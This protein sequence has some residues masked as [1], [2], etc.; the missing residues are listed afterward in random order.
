M[1]WGFLWLTFRLIMKQR[2]RTITLFC[3]IFFSSFLLNAFGSLGYYF[4]TQ[5]HE[6]NSDTSTF[7][8]TELALTAL[9]VILLTIVLVC[10]AVLLQNLFALTFF[11]KWHSLGRLITLGA[12]WQQL[13]LMVV[14]EVSIIYCIA[15]PLGLI[16]TIALERS[17]SIPVEI[18]GWMIYSIFSW[19][20]IASYICGL[21]P[22]HK[23]MQT[24]IALSRISKPVTIRFRQI[25]YGQHYN[26]FAVFMARKYRSANRGH[27]IRIVLTL[28]AVM[29]LYIPMLFYLHRFRHTA[30]RIIG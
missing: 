17:I 10:S 23:A 29:V 28:I 1:R 5:V 21:R 25:K 27:Y 26:S 4:W 3:G 12:T 13:F 11:Q 18:P 22:V 16:V 8:S 14:I 24:P 2:L 15:A 7:N 30:I 20:L 9:A 6:G 19:L